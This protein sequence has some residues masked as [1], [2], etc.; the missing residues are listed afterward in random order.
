MAAQTLRDELL[1][2]AA[3]P[4]STAVTVAQLVEM[5]RVERMPIRYSTRRSYEVW[6]QRYVLPGW[7][8]VPI[9]DVQPRPVE[10]WLTSLQLSAR[11]RSDIRGVL[12]RLCDFAMW[13]GVI[14]TQ[15]NPMSLVK[16]PDASKRTRQPLILTVVEFQQLVS[17][18]R[19]PFRTI[20]M[21]CVSLGLRIARQRKNRQSDFS[22]RRL[23][24]TNHP[25]P[26]FLDNHALGC[27]LASVQRNATVSIL[28]PSYEWP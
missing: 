8:G 3:L 12:G 9:A 26:I 1:C 27:I 16:V 2:P 25:T 21:L 11:R 20:A 28:L 13:S 4:V 10:L 6:L 14:S 5:Y 24:E 7:G 23:H 15:P 19:E 18:L 17:C 22:T